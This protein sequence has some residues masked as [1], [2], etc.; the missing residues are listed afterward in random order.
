MSLHLAFS[1]RHCLVS[2]KQK[3]GGNHSWHDFA[4]SILTSRISILCLY[5]AIQLC[6]K[7]MAG[8]L[9]SLELGPSPKPLKFC[10]N[11]VWWTFS[12]N[13]WIFVKWESKRSEIPQALYSALVVASS[14]LV[15]SPILVPMPLW[16]FGSGRLLLFLF[17]HADFN[18]MLM[19]AQ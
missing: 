15:P 10:G 17:C 13:C 12:K 14:H 3:I 4:L 16:S 2:N 6:T 1:L 11:L 7:H 5:G 9:A 18:T 8:F 19:L